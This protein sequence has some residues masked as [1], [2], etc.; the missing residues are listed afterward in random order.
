MWEI[1]QNGLVQQPANY[2]PPLVFVSKSF[3]GAV[4]SIQVH[5]VYGCLLLTKPKILTV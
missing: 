5:T 1:W 3:V 2:N 4:M